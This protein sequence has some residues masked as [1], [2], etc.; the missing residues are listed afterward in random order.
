MLWYIRRLSRFLGYCVYVNF[1]LDYSIQLI[2][3]FRFSIFFKKLVAL[4]KMS[5]I[6]LC[7]FLFFPVLFFSTKRSVEKH[8][9]FSCRNCLFFSYFCYSFFLRLLF[10]SEHLAQIDDYTIT[11]FCQATMKLDFMQ[12][13]TIKMTQDLFCL[14]H[15]P[16]RL[17]HSLHWF[18]LL[19]RL[20]SNIN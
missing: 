4:R 14:A 16:I 19:L 3:N 11:R 1:S 13:P 15:H 9:F 8:I 6:L 7:P 5:D 2:F 10:E 20:Y 12:Q 17:R 18:L